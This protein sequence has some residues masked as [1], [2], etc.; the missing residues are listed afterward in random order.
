MASH[1]HIGFTI[2]AGEQMQFRPQTHFLQVLAS[3]EVVLCFPFDVENCAK[4]VV[5]HIFLYVHDIK[6]VPQ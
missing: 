4:Y 5:H 1:G 6:V 3:C 2:I